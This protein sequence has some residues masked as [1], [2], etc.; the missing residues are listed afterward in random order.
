MAKSRS[1]R[2]REINQ[3]FEQQGKRLNKRWTRSA[4]SGI[5]LII[6]AI[7]VLQLTPYRD[8][9]KDVFNAAKSFLQ[10]L[11]SGKPAPVEPDPKYW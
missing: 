2:D 3:R 4:V 5:V 8:L 1:D 10:S 11:T 6:A 9:P 7:I